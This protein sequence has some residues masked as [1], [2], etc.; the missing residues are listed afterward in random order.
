MPDVSH[1]LDARIDGLLGEVDR[2]RRGRKA[3]DNQLQEILLK[4]TEVQLNLA[5]Q[6]KALEKLACAIHGAGDGRSGL[7]TR[8]DRMEHL[9]ANMIRFG[10]LALAAMVTAAAD[11]MLKVGK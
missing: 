5:T 3:S 7:L 10:W 2:L 8:V 6:D 11:V 9:T 1:Q 4:V